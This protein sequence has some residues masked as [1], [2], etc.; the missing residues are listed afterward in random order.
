[1]ALPLKERWMGLRNYQSK[2]FWAML[3]ARPMTILL[4]LPVADIP[5]VTPNLIT[6]LGVIAK[7]AGILLVAF[8]PS[9][10]GGLAGALLINLGLVMDNMDG[11]L[12]RYRHNGSII[13]YYV[14]KSVDIVGLAGMFIA[15][16]WRAFA[17]SGAPVDLLLPMT[18]F[19]GA[20]VAAYSKWIAARVEADVMLRKHLEEGT[21]EDYAR[22]RVDNNKSEAP[23]KRNAADWVRW[24]FSAITSLVQCNE[25]DI[26]F[27]V[28]LALALD[29][30]QL[31]T[32]YISGV[33][34]LGIIITPVFFYFQLKALLKTRNLT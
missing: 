30:V 7:L 22:S 24:F 25:V 15:L 32:R 17:Q 16:A 9:Y 13:G 21:L 5:W 31:F 33:Y 28:L 14:D 10:A 29:Y 20:S 1:M 2:D 12:A 26:Y 19:A 3:F 27:F 8:D 11:T 6:V 34:T 4:L 18:A 23:P